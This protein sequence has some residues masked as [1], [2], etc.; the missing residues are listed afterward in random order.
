VDA[1]AVLRYLRALR[2]F[3]HTVKHFGDALACAAVLEDCEGRLYSFDRKL[4]AV[5]GIERRETVTG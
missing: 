3:A 4:S 5:E 1:D 2:L